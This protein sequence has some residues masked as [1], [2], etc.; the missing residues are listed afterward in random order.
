VRIR[1]ETATDLE[2]IRRVNLEAFAQ[3]PLSQQTEHLIVD[4]LR[5]ADALA[6]SLVAEV[7]GEVVGHIAFS[8]APIGEAVSGWLLVGPVAVL[9]RYQGQGI[10]SA[11]V[12]GGLAVTRSAGALGCVLVG[13]PAFYGRFGFVA[14][15]SAVYEGVPG[16]FLLRMSFSGSEP[17]GA[18]VA[19]AAFSIQAD[20]DDARAGLQL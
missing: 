18:V 13:E 11:L 20:A 3:H 15:R 10:G 7:D 19:H 5:A 14:C 4:A 6:L 12:S 16:E 8:P 17:T 9:L 1:P 2:A